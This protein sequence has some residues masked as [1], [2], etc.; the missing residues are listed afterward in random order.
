MHMGVV[1]YSC[2]LDKC[3]CSTPGLPLHWLA[4]VSLHLTCCCRVQV[5]VAQLV[6]LFRKVELLHRHLQHSLKVSAES[7]QWDVG[8]GVTDCMQRAMDRG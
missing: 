8:R 3:V 7:Q 2:P 4:T 5:V 6:T 1:T